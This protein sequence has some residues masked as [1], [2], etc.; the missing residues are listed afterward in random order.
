M[1]IILLPYVSEC[2]AKNELSRANHFISRQALLYLGT[3]LFITALFYLFISTLT[4]VFFAESYL[5]T[6]GLSRIMILSILPQAIYLLYPNPIDADSVIPYN[7]IILG[8]CLFTM[9]VSFCFSTTLTQ[10][11]WAYL[12]VSLLQGILSFTTWHLIK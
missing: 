9:V 6:S 3:A 1:G 5:V 8:I 11:A 4:T 2:I 10:C 12:A 7:T